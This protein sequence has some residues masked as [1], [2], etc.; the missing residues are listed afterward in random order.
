[1]LYSRVL[2]KTLRDAPHDL[3][4]SSGRLL[5]RG[6][7]V[8]AIGQGLYSFL[9]L[10]LRVFRRIEAIIREEM[11]ALGGQEV[12]VPLVNPVE[13]WRRSGRLD[14]VGDGMVR[15]NDRYGHAYV[16]A[17]THEEAFVELVRA[18]LTSHR[19]LPMFLFQFQTKFRDEERVHHGLVRTKEFVMADGYSFHRSFTDLNNFFPK[20]FA[21]YRRVFGRCRVHTIAAEA[22]VGYMGGDRSYEFL[23]PCDFGDD[24]VVRC[25]SCGYVAN[26]EVAKAVKVSYPEHP[27]DLE[28]IETPGCNSMARLATHLNVPLRKLGKTMVF[29]ADDTLVLAV[30]RGDYE[31]SVEKL[32]KAVGRPVVLAE[33]SEVLEAGIESGFVSPLGLDADLASLDA[34]RIIVDE[35]IVGSSNLVMGANEPDRHYINVNFGRDFDAHA[36]ADIARLRN[37]ESC[38]F[39]GGPL[40]FEQTMEIANV[41]RLGTGYAKSMGLSY[42]DGDTGQVFPWMGSYGI[43]IARLMTAIVEANHDRHGIIWPH[44]VAPYRGYLMA[45]GKAP[46]LR[47]LV[48]RL[49]DERPDELL[50]DDRSDS[51]SSKLKDADLLGIPVRIIVSHESLEDGTVEVRVRCTGEVRRVPVRAVGD[52]LSEIEREEEEAW[53]S[54]LPK[55]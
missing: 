8:R 53:S 32:T 21:A 3:T 37:D 19:D 44:S 1:M 30:V 15:F 39:C 41:F 34:F 29:R 7:Y 33:P 47:T 54:S 35:S 20:V 52:V 25:D 51:I 46:S 10:G 24:D 2:S 17:P 6:G 12:L 13:I 18:G 43:G 5:L 9:P 14:V 50:M 28:V 48:H 22:G 49:H 40:R 31:I 38:Y 4:T 16:L 42:Y 11:V 55:S 45:I 26:R 23:V 36:V 27:R